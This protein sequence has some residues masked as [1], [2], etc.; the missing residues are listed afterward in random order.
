MPWP[1]GFRAVKEGMKKKEQEEQKK[2]EEEE[3]RTR[4]LEQ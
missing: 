1:T 4:L 2:K 3:E